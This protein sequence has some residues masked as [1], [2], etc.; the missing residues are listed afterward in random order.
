[1]YSG[2]VIRAFKNVCSSNNND[3]RTVALTLNIMKS[4]EKIIIGELRKEV[5]PSLDQY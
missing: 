4:F 3:Y 5:E 1:M 2:D